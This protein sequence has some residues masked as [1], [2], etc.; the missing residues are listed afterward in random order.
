MWTHADVIEFSEIGDSFQLSDAAGMKDGRADVVDQLSLNQLAIVNAV[1]DFADSQRRGGVLADEPEAFL[2][3]G[4]NRIFE[5]EEMGRFEF[6]A[7]A[8]GLDRRE[9]MVSIVKQMQIG[10]EFLRRRMKSCGTKFKYCSEDQR[11]SG[12]ASGSAG[13]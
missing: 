11:F 13:S 9:A 6:L 4:G 8:C 10:T 12:G 7:E 1:E 3:L 5:P 2:E